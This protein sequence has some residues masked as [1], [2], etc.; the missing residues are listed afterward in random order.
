MSAENSE[1]D[2]PT[3]LKIRKISKALHSVWFYPIDWTG[4]A[5]QYC[6]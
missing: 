2:P 3:E 6:G 4:E 5:R 1:H